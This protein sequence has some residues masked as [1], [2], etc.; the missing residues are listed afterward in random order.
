M[1]KK[2]K[3]ILGIGI[4]GILLIVV[5]TCNAMMISSKG[6]WEKE[7]DIRIVTQFDVI[8]NDELGKTVIDQ[9]TN[10]L[11]ES[12]EVL[13]SLEPIKDDISQFFQDKYGVDVSKKIDKLN[14]V[15][16]YT[17]PSY[18]GETLSGYIEESAVYFN[19]E[20]LSDDILKE[21]VFIHET[22][23]YLGFMSDENNDDYRYIMEGLT[24]AL[25]KECIEYHGKKYLPNA[26]ETQ[27]ALMEQILIVNP[28]L[29]VNAINFGSCQLDQIINS[30]LLGIRQSFKQEDDLAE[31]LELCIITLSYGTAGNSEF[32]IALQ[33]QD[34]VANYCKTFNPTK[35]QIK[36]IRSEYIVENFETIEVVED[37]DNYIVRS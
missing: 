17:A 10:I 21:N 13:N 12:K 16:I 7:S 23:H 15:Y 3:W 6:F 35:K 31:N 14:K 32:F 20:T 30:R 19:I 36:K 2:G 22:I 8:E 11:R 18:K 9:E 28:D 27:R 33:A 5:F 24:E 1:I 26:Y 34:I 4:I 37:G 25:T 29:V